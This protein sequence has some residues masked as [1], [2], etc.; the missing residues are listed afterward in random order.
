MLDITFIRENADVVKKAAKNKGI[1]VDIAALLKLDEERRKHISDRDELRAKQ[2]VV[3]DEIAKEKKKDERANKIG[4]M[5]HLKKDLKDAEDHIAKIE[6]KYNDLMRQVPNIPYKE[7]P[8]GV[9]EKD[10]KVLYEVGKHPSFSFDPLDYLSLAERHG[11]IDI[12]RASKVSGSRF[13]YIKGDLA[14]L[15]FAL[16]QYTL[17]KLTEAGFVAVV[18]PVLVKPEYMDAM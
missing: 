11:W 4:E 2:N 3:S 8:I 9:G 5:Q 13:G 7:V 12:E 14:L 6:V 16:V 18:P 1:D 17:A 15:E 10:N